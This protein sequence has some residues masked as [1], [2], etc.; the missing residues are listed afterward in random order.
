MPDWEKVGV[1]R[2]FIQVNL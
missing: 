1:L 2:Q